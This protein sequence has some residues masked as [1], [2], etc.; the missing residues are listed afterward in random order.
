MNSETTPE[1][2]IAEELE[3]LEVS[4]SQ[5]KALELEASEGLTVASAAANGAVIGSGEE[6]QALDLDKE[7]QALELEPQTLDKEPQALNLDKDP[8]T[9]DPLPAC[10]K[11]GKSGKWVF[12][13]KF[14]TSPGINGSIVPSSK[15][16]S[17]HM[18]AD[19]DFSAIDT[20]VEL[21]PGLGNFTAQYLERSKPGTKAVLFEIDDDY[22]R[23][24]QQRYGGAITLA[25]DAREMPQVL[26]ALGIGHVDLIVSSLPFT[27]GGAL[28]SIIGHIKRQ[29]ELGAVFRFY[30][31]V[32]FVMKRHYRSLPVC[33][34]AFVL[35]NLPP[36]WI[37]GVN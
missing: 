18:F 4:D 32:P 22:R 17:R 25:S 13:R 21:G 11:S 24:L 27:L 34:R 29:T 20:V 9:L 1:Q 2:A 28:P 12:A 23:H 37:Y 26:D 31:Y 8:Q 10:G 36:M 7:P 30:T 15:A 33:K 5:P 35:R 14:L 6:P 16:A 19:L 3:A